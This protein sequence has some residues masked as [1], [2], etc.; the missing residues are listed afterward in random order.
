MVQ[1]I[2]PPCV[3]YSEKGDFATEIFF[4]VRKSLQSL[5]NCLKE[6]GVKRFFITKRK[7]IELPGNGK[8]DMEVVNGQKIAH[9][10][11]DPLRAKQCL[12]FRTMPVPAGIIG[13][14]LVVAVI[15]PVYMS[16]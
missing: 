12:A 13:N 5:G 15:A 6:N 11:L 2:L 4:I 3:K 14:T 9:A 1:E 10:M 8:N 16:A 7:G